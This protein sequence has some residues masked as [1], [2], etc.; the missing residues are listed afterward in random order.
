MKVPIPVWNYIVS[1]NSCM[2][3][4]DCNNHHWHPHTIPQNICFT[5]FCCWWL[6]S[7]TVLLSHWAYACHKSQGLCLKK[8][9]LSYSQAVSWEI[10]SLLFPILPLHNSATYWVH[11][12]FSHFHC[13][14]LWF[15]STALPQ[16]IEQCPSRFYLIPILL[17][18]P[19][20]LWVQLTLQVRLMQFYI[21]KFRVSVVFR[22]T[23]ILRGNLD[24][25]PSQL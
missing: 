4:P 20:A 12:P 14:S 3:A 15:L 1:V 17:L 6:L 11:Y 7:G 9:K 5:A 25:I 2:S 18:L 21:S 22:K 24:K 10:Y 8:K 13:L 16:I 23:L 19:Q